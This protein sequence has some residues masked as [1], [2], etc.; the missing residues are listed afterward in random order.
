[1]QEILAVDDEQVLPLLQC[2]DDLPDGRGL[3]NAGP[4]GQENDRDDM[5]CDH[6][7]PAIWR[8]Y[9]GK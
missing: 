6:S 8:S 3:A 2:V 5:V 9:A 7:R 4:S 1:M